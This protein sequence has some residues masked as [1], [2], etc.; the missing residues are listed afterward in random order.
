[1]GVLVKRFSILAILLSFLGVEKIAHA[2][3]FVPLPAVGGKNKNLKIKFV[4][5]DG[6]TNGQMVVE[7]RNSSKAKQKFAADGI[8]FVPKGNPDSAPQRLGASGPMLEIARNKKLLK[9]TRSLQ[10]APGETKKIRLEVF[11]IDSHRSSPNRSTKFSIAKKL[12]PKKLRRKLRTGNERIYRKY[13]N[14]LK[15]AKSA[16]QSNM[17]KT[18]DAKWDKLQGER[19][20][21]KAQKRSPSRYQNHGNRRPI[22]R[23]KRPLQLKN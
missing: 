16:I 5:Y 8:Y 14:N 15:R 17:W 7:I 6:G 12:L 2:D 13:K 9:Q 4:K 21:E 23:H 19:A 11:C 22:R 1:M 20:N 10:L 18:R 3:K